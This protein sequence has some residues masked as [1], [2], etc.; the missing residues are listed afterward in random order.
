MER[1][2][3]GEEPHVEITRQDTRRQF[4]EKT[5]EQTCYSVGVPVFLRAK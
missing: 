5:F 1:T 2:H 4:P 3:D